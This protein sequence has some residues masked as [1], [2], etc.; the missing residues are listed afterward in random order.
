MKGC[1]YEKKKFSVYIRGNND[2]F[3]KGCYNCKNKNT[4]I[5]KNCTH[6]WTKW[7]KEGK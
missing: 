2:T 5:C 6:G 1:E 7:E 3:G 4:D